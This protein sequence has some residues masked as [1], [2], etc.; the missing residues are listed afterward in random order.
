[1]VPANKICLIGTVTGN[2]TTPKIHLIQTLHKRIFG[3]MYE[4]IRS[5]L[6]S[7]CAKPW[8]YMA[9]NFSEMQ[10][11]SKDIPSSCQ[12]FQSYDQILPNYFYI[13]HIIA[14]CC[15]V[16]SSYAMF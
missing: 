8:L 7:R 3:K 1:M 13:C 12:I 6:M 10:R 9:M 16:V 15:I 2:K 4:T 11:I 14:V 5:K